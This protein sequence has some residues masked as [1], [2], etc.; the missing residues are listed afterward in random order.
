MTYAY[1]CKKCMKTNF[2]MK[3]KGETSSEGNTGMKS[4]CCH[5]CSN[6][7]CKDYGEC[8]CFEKNQEIRWGHIK[9]RIEEGWIPPV[10]DEEG[11]DG[12]NPN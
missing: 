2:S 1:D 9:K 7:E 8:D 10:L 11:S 4:S 12:D 3:S 6:P 5:K